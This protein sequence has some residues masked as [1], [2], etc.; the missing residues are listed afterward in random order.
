MLGRKLAR[1]LKSAIYALQD[2]PSETVIGSLMRRGRVSLSVAESCTAGLL[3]K[4][5]TDAAGSSRYF[6]GGIIA[7]ANRV[8]HD[9]LS[10]TSRVL[11]RH[12]AVSRQVALQM[13]RDVR[14]RF[15]SHLGVSITGIAGPGGGTRQ[16][17]VGLV[18]IALASK[19][20]SC[21][22]RFRLAGTRERIR[23]MATQRALEMLYQRLTSNSR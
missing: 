5:L 1:G 10:V 21:A 3:A 14:L 11:E 20:M 23:F 4:R 7:Y 15:K 19:N 17:P 16:K 18:W 22:R 6:I 12:G 8:K 2:M 9:F 13:A